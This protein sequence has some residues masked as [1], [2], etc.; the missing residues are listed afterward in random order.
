M[1]F[2]QEKAGIET[3]GRRGGSGGG[4]G[5][6]VEPG[7]DQDETAGRNRRSGDRPGEVACRRINPRQETTKF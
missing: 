2:N 6:I 7:E 3:A 4:S 5:E 1:F